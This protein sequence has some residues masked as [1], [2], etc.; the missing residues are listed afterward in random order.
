MVNL[1]GN[2]GIRSIQKAHLNVINNR[3]TEET[4]HIEAE[5]LSSALLRENK[6]KLDDEN[7]IQVLDLNTAPSKSAATKLPGVD[8]EN[9]SKE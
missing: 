7:K 6:A 8:L 5:E 1:T 3:V 9:E 2:N 4:K